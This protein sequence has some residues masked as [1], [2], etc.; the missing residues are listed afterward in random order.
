MSRQPPPRTA[1]RVPLADRIRPTSLD[2]VRGQDHLLAPGAPL[3]QAIEGDRLTSLLLWGPPG[4][5]KT[6]LARLL[7]DHT[8]AHFE[9]FSAVMG[10]VK[11]VRRI[12]EHARSR[13]EGIEQRETML[14]VDEIHRFNK[15]QQDAFL[16]HVES[17]L[18]TLV[19]ATTENP[20]FQ[21]IPALL[22][23]CA[24]L[25]L[26]P[27]LPADLQLILRRALANEEHGLGDSGLVLEDEVIER[28]ALFAGGD[29]RKALGALERVA[30]AAA[31]RA[32]D[33]GPITVDEAAAML[34]ADSLLYDRAGEEHYNVISAFIKS[35]RG[36]D[37]DAALYWM[38]RMLEAGE[39]PMF[40]ARRLVVLASED[41]G[42]ADPRALQIALATKDAVHFLGLPEA[43]FPLSQA[44]I[45]LATAPKSNSAGAYFAA[46]KAARKH[47]ALPV[48]V[49]LR[50]AATALMKELGYGEG[51]TY[52]HEFEGNHVAAQYL[53]DDLAG[54]RFF[55]PGDQ[56]F[57]KTIRQRLEI[58]ESRRERG[59]QDRK[60]KR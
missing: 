16:P 33:A 34:G 11:D 37:V 54:A 15:A 50:N 29:A 51:Y 27:L 2:E 42:N 53:P 38:A 24:V 22:S 58:W 60:K 36:S 21:V 40:V 3:R 1:P 7:A 13:R 39:D 19:G 48:P 28:L 26:H 31:D 30:L 10:S 43:R 46:A 4:A 6:T 12:V 47:G 14:F 45:Y 59:V 8:R 56:G 17:G 41:V 32:P 44:T 52:P 9:A 25:V 23:R 35:V 18:L 55:Q 57:E 20:S 49:H 5:G